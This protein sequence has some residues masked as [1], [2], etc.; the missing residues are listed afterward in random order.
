MKITRSSLPK[1]IIELV[2]EET[3]EN[4]A[5]FR[6]KAVSDL[7]NKAEIKW[8]RKWVPIPENIIVRH[9]G[10]PHLLALAVEYAVDSLYKEAIYNEGIIPV[11]QALITEVRSQSPLI[12]VVHIETLPEVEIKK[13]YKDIKF[14]KNTINV[15]DSE[16]ESTL[17]EIQTKFA[18]F[19]EVVDENAKVE[20]WDRVTIDTDWYDLDWNFLD[21]TSMKEY[22]L[23]I[24]SKILVPWFEEWLIWAKVW[25][26]L[27]LDI[28]FPNDYHNKSFAGKKTKFSVKIIKL[29]KSKKPEFTPEFI[30]QLRW[31]KLDLAWFKDLIKQELLDVKESNDRFEQ[32]NKLIEELLKFTTM[33]IWEGLLN[34]QIEKV[35]AEIKENITKDWLKV[36]DYIDSLK[37]TEESYKET[38]VK[39]I[40]LKRLHWELILHK[41]MEIEKTEVS[42]EQVDSEISVIMSRFDSED[43][44]KR[45]K[46]LYVPW[47]KYYEELK[48]RI[49][50]RNLIDSF[51]E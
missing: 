36:S 38:N 43:V 50:Y 34:N 21:S 25:E 28:T 26:N 46:E 48:Q 10:E 18:K 32:E 8:F 51:F 49:A 39:P 17:N 15:T 11:A 13:E 14:K 16:V 12:F 7:Q 31:K 30:E 44:L 19:E 2:I 5:K 22:P 42:D 29:E 37:L 20:M 1:S 9:Y 6:K 41:L 35:F 47:T 40:A 23:I 45:L 27:N 3:A 33:D 24:G 4:V